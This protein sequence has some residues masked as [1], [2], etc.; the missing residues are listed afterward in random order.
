MRNCQTIGSTR[1]TSTSKGS[2]DVAYCSHDIETS[3]VKTTINDNDRVFLHVKNN[4]KLQSDAEQ[5]FTVRLWKTLND[6]FI[7]TNMDLKLNYVLGKFLEERYGEEDLS[8]SFIIFQGL[9]EAT[10]NHFIPTKVS[11]QTN[12]KKI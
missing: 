9:V 6:S 5:T 2:I 12:C 4:C 8:A 3:I 7:L 1:E 11:I 10:I